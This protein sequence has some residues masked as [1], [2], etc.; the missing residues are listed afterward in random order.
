MYDQINV[1]T[2][3]S[4]DQNKIKLKMKIVRDQ[5]AN[6]FQYCIGERFLRRVATLIP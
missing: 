1:Q 3:S 5:I 6:S 2:P 4:K